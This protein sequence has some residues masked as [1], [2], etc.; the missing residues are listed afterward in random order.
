MSC[1]GGATAPL[2]SS[3][4]E[5]AFGLLSDLAFAW[6]SIGPLPSPPASGCL[7]VISSTA[8]STAKQ[9]EHT[10][11][12]FQARGRVK[13]WVIARWADGSLSNYRTDISIR[14][15]LLAWLK[16]DGFFCVTKTTYSQEVC[17]SWMFPWAHPLEQTDPAAR[18]NHTV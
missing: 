2:S 5:S 9:S 3:S 7:P 15:T 11:V 13:R 1:M 17:I 6:F 12:I 4:S 10:S 8:A 18:N 14:A 16:W